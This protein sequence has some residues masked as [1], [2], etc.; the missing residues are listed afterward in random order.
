MLAA[1]IVSGK[2]AAQTPLGE[3]LDV[4]MCPL[5]V[6]GAIN[7]LRREMLETLIGRQN[8]LLVR[9]SQCL[10]TNR[11]TPGCA[12]DETPQEKPVGRLLSD[13]TVGWNVR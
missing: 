7:T 1:R 5:G 3:K 12:R 13:A 6:N 2:R 10:V 9:P 11:L 8:D 4:Q